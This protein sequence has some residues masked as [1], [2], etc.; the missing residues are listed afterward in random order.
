MPELSEE[1][2]QLIENQFNNWA[3]NN[4]GLVTENKKILADLTL[5][6]WIFRG[7]LAFLLGGSIA[8]VLYIPS[9]VDERIVARAQAID[10]LVIANG[11]LQAGNYHSAF[12]N[13][14]SFIGRLAAP[15]DKPLNLTKLSDAQKSFFFSTLVGALALNSDS[16]PSA[17]SEFQG[18]DRWRA[19]LADEDFKRLFPS[20]SKGFSSSSILNLYMGL[21]YLRYADGERD[22]DQAYRY[23]HA[24]DSA[25]KDVPT[26]RNSNNGSEYEAVALALLGRRDEAVSALANLD[27]SAQGYTS[28]E[29]TYGEPSAQF[30]LGEFDRMLFGRLWKRFS[31]GNLGIDICALLKDGFVAAPSTKIKDLDS[32]A[33]RSEFIRQALEKYSQTKAQIA[34]SDYAAVSS[35]LLY[36]PTGS[37]DQFQSM[38][39]SITKLDTG[40]MAAS[41]YSVQQVGSVITIMVR[42]FPTETDGKSVAKESCQGSTPQTTQDEFWSFIK[43]SSSDPEWKLV[44]YAAQ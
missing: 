41:I 17:L 21:A 19:M 27:L 32:A 12:S 7:I 35:S 37:Q 43:Q 5:Y 8:G 11:D 10:D 34:R 22:L 38:L 39:S 33:G 40:K 2:K 3:K 14:T 18:K 20:D 25:D 23:L 28:Y 9:W 44:F 16:D 26:S 6:K 24:A 15:A 13:M 31:K 4:E 42:F 36:R 30:L 1:Q 29:L